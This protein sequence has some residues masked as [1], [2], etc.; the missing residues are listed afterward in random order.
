MSDEP[1]RSPDGDA[2]AA[3]LREQTRLKRIKSASQGAKRGWRRK[4]RVAPSPAK[5]PAKGAAK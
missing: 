3:H 2:I 4:K 1:H 5:A